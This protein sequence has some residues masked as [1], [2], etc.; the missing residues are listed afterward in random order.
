MH[1]FLATVGIEPATFGILVPANALPTELCGQVGSSNRVDDISELSLVP[2][3]SCVFYD[4]IILF[5]DTI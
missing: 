5:Y 2:S 1:P 3:I 4:I